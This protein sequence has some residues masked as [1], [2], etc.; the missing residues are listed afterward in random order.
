MIATED[1]V[2]RHGARLEG[3]RVERGRWSG[4]GYRLCGPPGLEESR[5]PGGPQ[6]LGY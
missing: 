5:W 4:A 1:V 2:V 6:A 3:G